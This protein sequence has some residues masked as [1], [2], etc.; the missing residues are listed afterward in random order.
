MDYS[1]SLLIKVAEYY[2]NED[3]NQQQIAKRLN[4]SRVKVSRLLTEARNKGIVKIEIVYPKDNCIE[5]ERQLEEKYHL[6]EVVIISS[7]SNSPDSI[8]MEVTNTAAQFIEEKVNP[9]DI[10]GIAWGRTLKRVSD[11]IS[12]V[13]KEVE[14]VQ[15]LGNIGSS[16]YSGDVIVRNIAKSFQGSIYLLPAPAIVD[17]IKIKEAIKSD[18]QISSILDMQKQCSLAIVGIGQVSENSTLVVS[19]YLK[20]EDLERLKS[21]GAVGEVV[22]RFVDENGQICKTS[23]NDRVLGIEIDSLKEIP[24]V[25][26]IASGEEKGKSI[27]AVLKTGSI[28]VLITDENTAQ[29]ILKLE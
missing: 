4:I 21:D 18:G 15:L 14:I 11:R 1:K 28:D 19:N 9:K 8:H 10:I 5:L 22:G 23:V 24:C 16:E 17:N 3:L 7:S 13:N 26:A 12:E 2:Y 20:K 25:V 6:E 27:K 29:N